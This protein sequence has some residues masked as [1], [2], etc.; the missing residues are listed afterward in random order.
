MIPGAHPVCGCGGDSPLNRRVIIPEYI[1]VLPVY[2]TVEW[3][4]P[5]GLL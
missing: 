2:N 5:R 3:V 4:G 1:E